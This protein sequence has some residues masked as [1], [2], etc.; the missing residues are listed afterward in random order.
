MSTS[1]NDIT[2]D[3]IATKYTSE[4]FRRNF[5]NIFKAKGCDRIQRDDVDCGHYECPQP[6]KVCIHRAGVVGT[7]E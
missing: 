6:T 2:G 7:I 5:D 1:T 3:K 4:S